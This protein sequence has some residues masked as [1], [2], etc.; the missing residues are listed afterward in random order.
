MV[1]PLTERNMMRIGVGFGGVGNGKSW[2][3]NLALKYLRSL[4]HI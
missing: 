1:M 3:F 4:K 2:N